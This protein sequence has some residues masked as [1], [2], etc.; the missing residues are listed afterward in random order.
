MALWAMA[1]GSLA[2]V[3]L[4]SFAATPPG[5]HVFKNA[6]KVLH[7]AGY[8]GTSFLFLLAA[9]WRPGR[10]EGRFPGA[11]TWIVLAAVAGG[12]AIEIVQGHLGRQRSSLDF[13]ADVIGVLVALGLWGALKRR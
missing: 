8:A 5:A 4:F 13:L 11:A 7:A 2:L 3:A 6:D 10:G 9:V 12:F 1:F